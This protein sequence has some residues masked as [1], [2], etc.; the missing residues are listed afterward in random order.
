MADQ[1]A[2]ADAA[3]AAAAAKGRGGGNID[4]RSGVSSCPGGDISGY[5]NGR[6]PTSLLC[7]LYAAPGHLLRADAAAA[8][9]NM[10]AAYAGTFG[11]P[12]CVTDSYRPLSVQILLKRQKPGLAATP[13]RSNHG[14]AR[15]VDLCGGIQSFGS[16]QHVWMQ[17]N[18]PPVRLVRSVLVARR[19]QQTRS[20]ALEYLDCTT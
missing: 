18:A 7:P 1:K 9:N 17:K 15:A 4:P 3:A 12:I 13:G 8:F 5:P 10:S 11:A 20:L 14:M 6:I 2:Q 19:R 16:A